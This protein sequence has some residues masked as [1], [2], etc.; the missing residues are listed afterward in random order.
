MLASS[1]FVEV[2]RRLPHDTDLSVFLDAGH[3]GLNFAFLDGSRDYH[4]ASDVP[5]N[6][7]L[8]SLQHHGEVMLA[9]A[10]RLADADPASWAPRPAVFFNLGPWLVQYPLDWSL[11]ILVLALLLVGIACRLGALAGR[12]RARFTAGALLATLGATAFAALLTLVAWRLV[13]ATQPIPRGDPRHDGPFIAGLLSLAAAAVAG[14]Q[15]GLL[16]FRSLTQTDVMAGASLSG[17]LFGIVLAIAFPGATYLAIWPTIGSAVGLLLTGHLAGVHPARARL[18]ALAL[19]ALPL[20]LLW[21]PLLPQLYLGLSLNRA[22]HL[23]VPVALPLALVLPQLLGPSARSMIRGALA[24][25][26]VAL[27]CLVVGVLLEGR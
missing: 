15:A 6:L 8:D 25:L 19:P 3:P 18:L 17:C 4:A 13:A 11:P 7:E 24:F 26:A 2:Y 20:L 10:R 5:A 23:A 16:R 27:A 1:L 12:L 9:L 14:V 21:A 22:A